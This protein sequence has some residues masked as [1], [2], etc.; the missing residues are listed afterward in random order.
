M[1]IPCANGCDAPAQRYVRYYREIAGG[2]RIYPLGNV[3]TG[4]VCADCVR[5]HDAGYDAYER[6]LHRNGAASADGVPQPSAADADEAPERGEIGSSRAT[7]DPTSFSTGDA[8]AERASVLATDAML[9][10]TSVPPADAVPEP[11]PVG[12]ADAIPEPTS[13]AFDPT[14]VPSGDGAAKQ[15]VQLGL[16]ALVATTLTAM[17]V[18]SWR[19][20]RRRSRKT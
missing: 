10:P 11:T 2:S 13:V 8:I 20:A 18:V 15:R 19:A 9:E 5:A 4:L 17:I 16:G 6:R 12:T 7:E 14:S 1:T 3:G